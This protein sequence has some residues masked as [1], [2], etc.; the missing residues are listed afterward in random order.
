MSHY[1]NDIAMVS[2]LHQKKTLRPLALVRR[3][4]QMFSGNVF[5]LLQKGRLQTQERAKDRV[6]VEGP[7]LEY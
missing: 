6:K 4:A 1:S 7:V 2:F 3:R 5:C